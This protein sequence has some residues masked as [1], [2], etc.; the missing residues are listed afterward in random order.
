MASPHAPSSPHR[1]RTPLIDQ[2]RPKHTTDRAR[3]LAITIVHTRN[4]PLHQHH[5]ALTLI[6][7]CRRPHL[8]PLDHRPLTRQHPL[9]SNTLARRTLIVRVPLLLILTRQIVLTRRLAPIR[10]EVHPHL[11]TRLALTRF[12]RQTHTTP[13]HTPPPPSQTNPPSVPPPNTHVKTTPSPPTAHAN[14]PR[15]ACRLPAATRHHVKGIQNPPRCRVSL[16]P[17]QQRH[18]QTHRRNHR[19]LTPQTH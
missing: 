15:Q 4:G 12:L 10:S 9:R 5:H 2:T 3:P 16:S 14:T 7:L 13:F 1:H 11:L 17:R 18:R 19:H 6:R 8:S